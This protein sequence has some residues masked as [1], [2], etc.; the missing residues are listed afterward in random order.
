MAE[1]QWRI[2]VGRPESK[3]G[4]GVVIFK[5]GRILGGDFNF[6]FDGQYKLQTVG[7]SFRGEMTDRSFTGRVTLTNFGES[8][9]SRFGPV[10]HNGSIDVDIEGHI[11]PENHI[12]GNAY[13][14]AA[15]GQQQMLVLHLW[16][17]SQ[18]S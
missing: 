18:L 3:D 6:Y 12:V 4:A 15:G 5:N 14:K 11:E 9:I 2:V 1:G 10:A 13:Y 17:K 7:D 8:T 16:K